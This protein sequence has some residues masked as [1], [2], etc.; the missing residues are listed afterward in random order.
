MDAGHF[1][2]SKHVYRHNFTYTPL[3]SPPSVTCGA[4]YKDYN[5]GRLQIADFKIDREIDIG[6]PT[7]LVRLDPR[8]TWDIENESVMVIARDVDDLQI[9]YG[10][11]EAALDVL[12]FDL[13]LT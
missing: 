13:L 1:N 11:D 8:E 3:V 5:F 6:H 12:D 10:I 7:L 9:S 2:G 4:G